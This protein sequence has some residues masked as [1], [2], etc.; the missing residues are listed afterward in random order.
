M[1]I[2]LVVRLGLGCLLLTGTRAQAG[3]VDYFGAHYGAKEWSSVVRTHSFG[4]TED[5]YESL[6]NK[7]VTE[8]QGYPAEEDLVLIVGGLG[9]GRDPVSVASYLDAIEADG[10]ERWKSN[11]RQ[12]AQEVA[13]LAGARRVVWQIGNAITSQKYCPSMV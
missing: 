7:L 13:N 10:A 11:V 4:V 12:R 6:S 5:T 9:S 8:L 3:W 1:N 2:K